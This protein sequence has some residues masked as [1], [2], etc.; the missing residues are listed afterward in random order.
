MQI[1]FEQGTLVFELLSDLRLSPEIIEDLHRQ[2]DLRWDLRIKKFRA[3][4]SKLRPILDFLNQK[5]IHPQYKSISENPIGNTPK[6]EFTKSWQPFD[7]RKYQLEAFEHW[8][9]QDN[10]GVVVLP[11]GAGKTRLG[12]F[13]I[14]TLAVTT[15][16]LVP[17]R[18]LLHQWF[19]VIRTYYNG[20]V[21]LL[22]DSQK[23]IESIT[24]AT[25]ESA[26][27]WGLKTIS[28]EKPRRSIYSVI[29]WQFSVLL[30]NM[31]KFSDY[32]TRTIVLFYSS[33]RSKHKKF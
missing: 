9:R 2:F 11:T 4:A 26:K 6:L 23:S 28:K 8:T 10:L 17:T 20:K 5:G 24:I 21:G 16:I 12:L 18:V 3:P 14:K 32:R 27:N 29:N 30:I 22:G 13:C 7:L 33:E 25:Y 1:K 31:L 19:E 15:L